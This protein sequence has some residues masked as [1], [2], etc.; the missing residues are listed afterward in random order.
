MEPSKAYLPFSKKPNI[1]DNRLWFAQ[2]NSEE[3]IFASNSIG[4]TLAKSNRKTKKKV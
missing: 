4:P 2:N 1:D 3:K